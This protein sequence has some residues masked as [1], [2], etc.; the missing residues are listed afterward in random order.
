MAESEHEALQAIERGFAAVLP[1]QAAGANSL[2]T[3]IPRKAIV[4]R[5]PQ[6]L[7]VTT[8]GGCARTP[9]AN[10]TRSATCEM[11]SPAPKRSG[12]RTTMAIKAASAMRLPGGLAAGGV[13]MR[14]ADDDLMSAIF[15]W[16]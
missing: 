15:P 11:R 14:R 3:T 1:N 13:R 4:S 9:V 7:G 10:R 12:P 8:A 6:R 5:F 16:P 2:N